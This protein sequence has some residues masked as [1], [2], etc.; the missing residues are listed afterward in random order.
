ME[1][2]TLQTIAKA[3]AGRYAG[4]AISIDS[5][6]TDSR[7][8]KPGC[9]FIAIKGDN[10]DGHRHLDQAAAGG[11]AAVMVHADGPSLLP[12]IRVDDTRRAMG[13]LANSIR[14]RFRAKVIGVGGSNGKT[15]TKHLI[16]AALKEKLRGTAS[17]KSFNNDI[18]VPVTIFD[19]D[20]V[21]DFVILE[22]GTNHPGEILNLTKIAEP[23]IAVITSIGAEHLEFLGDLDGV[24]RENADIVRGLRPKSVLIFNGDDG[25]LASRLGSFEGEKVTFG[26]DRAND[27]CVTDLRCEATGIRFRINDSGHDFFVPLLGRHTASNALAAIAVAR[28][29]GVDDDSIATGLAEVKGPQ[30]RLQVQV[31]GGVTFLNDAYNANPH[32]MRAALETVRDMSSAGRKIAVLGDMRE[33]GVTSDLLHREMGPIA[34]A[35][36]LDQ[37]WCVG[38]KA[39]LIGDHARGISV[40][41]RYATAVECAADATTFFESGDLILLKGSRGVGL[42]RIANACASS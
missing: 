42:E 10:H 36:G 40:V 41:K 1:R 28:H 20:P 19:A 33:L 24:R 23:D 17:P 34:S 6:C 31:I 14:Q 15:G 9:L 30:W 12:A 27:L 22:M 25:D 8:I 3:T 11:A 21:H 39:A 29:M 4:P 26:F 5:I 18:G 13:R 37:L 38:E 16:E 7:A 32:S 2:L 35:C